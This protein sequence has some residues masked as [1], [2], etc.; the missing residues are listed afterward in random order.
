MLLRTNGNLRL[1]L[2]AVGPCG[3]LQVLA[4]RFLLLI[5]LAA[6]I[7]DFV[8]AGDFDTPFAQV[9]IVRLS[10]DLSRSTDGQ[11]TWIAI[12]GAGKLPVTGFDN[13]KR[14]G[15]F[16]RVFS[17]GTLDP[18]LAGKGFILLPTGPVSRS[19]LPKKMRE[20]VQ[21]DCAPV[22]RCLKRWL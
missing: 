22:N 7:E 12:N 3:Y 10:V 1:A 5:A 21:N 19:V 9:G 14:S 18:G 16:A 6:G 8:T 13:Q 20:I 2:N 4:V 15:V 17:P 11:A